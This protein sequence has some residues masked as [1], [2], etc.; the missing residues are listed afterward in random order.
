MS[1]M[2]VIHAYTP[3]MNTNLDFPK[4]GSTSLSIPRFSKEIISDLLKRA[5]YLLIND[6]TIL[7]LEGDYTVVGD[8]H[9]N[10]RDL[11]RIVAFSGNP[12]MCPY[13]FLGD[14][15]DRGAHSVEVIT[16]LLA[17]KVAF[18]QNV[19]LLRG[20]HEFAEVN[21]NYG[22]Y[23][24]CISL[25]DEEIY[26]KF[27]EVF[28]YLPLGAVV[29]KTSFVVHGGIGS[30]FAGIA[31]LEHIT[32]PITNF[33]SG[34]LAR[35]VQDLMW[36]DPGETAVGFCSSTRG[37]GAIFGLDALRNFLKISRLK[38]LIRAHQC[39][40]NGVEKL[41]HGRIYTIFSSS[42]YSP[43]LPNKAGIIRFNNETVLSY[44][45]LP[46][47]Q[48]T[49]A[50]TKYKDFD[51]NSDIQPLCTRA[52]RTFVQARKPYRVQKNSDGTTDIVQCGF[53]QPQLKKL[54]IKLK[55]QSVEPYAK[56]PI[57][58]KQIRYVRSIPKYSSMTLKPLELPTE[59]LKQIEKDGNEDEITIADFN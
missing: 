28:S 19:Y 34:K 16:L 31:D 6:E 41:F 39:V 13:L 48:L 7:H 30:S 4:L 57:Q 56:N 43:F 55:I 53:T 50:E 49:A 38:N 26:N 1:A 27:N 42:S 3:L 29:N 2:C 33:K 44:N 32:R 47:P 59:Q 14:Y 11:L 22:F 5:L 9:G 36:S 8:L 46:V 37:Y 45:F 40:Q 18:P 24:Q 35:I 58:Q 52:H 20:N 12:F 21:K 51:N 10:I 25:Y 54:T 17:F 23:Q 15:V